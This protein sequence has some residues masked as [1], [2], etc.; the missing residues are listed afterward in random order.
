MGFLALL[1]RSFAAAPR[2]VRE[3]YVNRLKQLRGI[4]MRS[5]K[6]ARDYLVALCLA[7]R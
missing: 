4:A 6:T 1:P 5:D 7:R 2:N 3:R